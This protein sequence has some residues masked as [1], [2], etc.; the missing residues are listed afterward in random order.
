MLEYARMGVQ[1][2]GATSGAAAAALTAAFDG[3]LTGTPVDS[4]WM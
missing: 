3:L 2:S 4:D 1:L